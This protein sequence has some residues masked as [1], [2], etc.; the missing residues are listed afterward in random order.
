MKAH[1]THFNTRSLQFEL[2]LKNLLLGHGGLSAML[3]A[4]ASRPRQRLSLSLLLEAQD[5]QQE[6][7]AAQTAS[8]AVVASPPSARLGAPVVPLIVI[9][10]I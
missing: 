1:I 4:P 9:I 6:S 10:V 8:G 5:C 7:V 3:V 2:M